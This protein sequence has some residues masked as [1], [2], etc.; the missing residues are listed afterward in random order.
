[1]STEPCTSR[2]IAGAKR[3]GGQ[4]RGYTR[5]PGPAGDGSKEEGRVRKRFPL[6]PQYPTP[7]RMLAK[8]EP[9]PRRTPALALLLW[10]STLTT[11]LLAAE[12]VTP[13]GVSRRCF[14]RCPSRREL[15]LLAI[16]PWEA[17]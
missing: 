3:A 17:F 4:L 13:P 16:P 1:V 9:R 5:A 10:N 7:T 15:L 14:E 11:L 8:K 2:M 12:P 6:L